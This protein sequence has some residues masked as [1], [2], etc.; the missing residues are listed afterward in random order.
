MAEP[1]RRYTEVG[2]LDGIRSVLITGGCGFIGANLVRFLRAETPWEV[3]VLDNLRTGRREYV[4]DDLAQVHEGDAGDA[5]ALRTA[6]DGVDAVVHLASTTGVLPSVEDPA[7]DFDGNPATTFR[8]LEACRRSG[9]QRFVFASSGAALGDAGTVL[10]ENLPPRPLSPYGA[11][12]LAGEAYCAAFAGS[13]DMHTVALRFSNVYGPFSMHK[14]NAIPNFI[15]ALLRGEAIEIFGD[16]QQSRDFIYVDD[17]CRGIMLALTSPAA[18][19]EVFQLATGIETT[20]ADLV[21]LIG[22]AV[23]S[24]QEIVYH[25]RRSGEVYKSRADISKV[26]ETLGYEP[27]VPLSEGLSRTVE[28]Y[29]ERLVASA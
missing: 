28:W 14:Q 5:D 27:R 15:K 19:G 6:L 29:R 20:I 16:G 10:H 23:G 1:I 21:T 12:K 26:K 4:T 13:F 9:T 2:H 3:R 24:D 11:G 7:M 22:D 8:I 17:L 18:K 25:P